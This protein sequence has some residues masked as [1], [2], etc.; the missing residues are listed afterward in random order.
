[1]R[2]EV[3]IFHAKLLQT[4]GNPESVSVEGKTVGECLDDLVRQ[5][6]DIEGL[7]FDKRHEMHHHMF[8]FVNSE[9]LRKVEMARS[10]KEGDVLIIAA[11]ITGG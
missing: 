10:M 4:M 9:S 6:P 2:S 3:R 11:L 1:M 8:V 5:Y 7:V